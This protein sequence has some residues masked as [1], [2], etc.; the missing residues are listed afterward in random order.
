MDFD[1]HTVVAKSGP[2]CVP[3][4]SRTCKEGHYP[5]NRKTPKDTLLR[6]PPPPLPGS[7]GQWKPCADCQ[8]RN[9]LR[10]A[11]R[12]GKAAAVA[13]LRQSSEIFF[14]KSLW[15]QSPAGCKSLI[16][17]F[18]CPGDTSTNKVSPFA[19]RNMWTQ[20]IPSLTSCSMRYEHS[21]FAE[22]KTKRAQ[23]FLCSCI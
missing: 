17:L 2:F 16:L 14:K 7:R 6:R 4:C 12:F 3:I 8:V 9:Y 21:P 15:F 23:L 20:E 5:I 19:R 18:H 13:H 1:S 22:L 10:F 11:Q